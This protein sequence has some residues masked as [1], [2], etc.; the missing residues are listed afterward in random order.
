MKPGDK[1]VLY[2]GSG[3]WGWYDGVIVAVDELHVSYELVS[4]SDQSKETVTVPREQ[5]AECV[6]SGYI[7]MEET[8]D[9]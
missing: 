8:K 1:F 3:M 5:F 9:E 6:E 7:T 4:R 2:N